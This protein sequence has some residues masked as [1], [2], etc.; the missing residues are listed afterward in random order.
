MKF[1][2]I[3]LLSFFFFILSCGN[4]S[5]SDESDA[6][7]AENDDSSAA[8]TEDFK[9]KSPCDLVS[10]E[11]MPRLTGIDERFKLT[12]ENKLLSH[13]TCIYRWDAILVRTKTYELGEAL[14]SELPAQIN[15]VMI[16]DQNNSDF[17]RAIKT[18]IDPKTLTNIGEM[19][20]W[21]DRLSQ[22]TVLEQDHIFHVYVNVDNSLA[23][24]RAIAEKIAKEIV[25]S[26]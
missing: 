12:I 4:S 3:L 10:E 16:R 23:K 17:T 13:P 25:V 15:I 2:S 7:M 9:I 6:E 14:E 8:G 5:A 22:L 1:R 24:N 21:G 18:Y 26:I 11:E 19:A 20:V